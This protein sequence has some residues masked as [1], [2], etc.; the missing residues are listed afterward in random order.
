MRQAPRRG[1]GQAPLPIVN[2]VIPDTGTIIA[3]V[4]ET[5]VFIV[6]VDIML[7]T[8]MLLYIPLERDT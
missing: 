8:A 4:P 5:L 1:N 3:I 7:S 6:I 2:S